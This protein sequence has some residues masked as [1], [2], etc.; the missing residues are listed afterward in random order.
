MRLRQRRGSI[1]RVS[2]WI[3][4]FDVGLVCGDTSAQ[5][6]LNWIRT[7]KEARGRWCAKIIECSAIFIASSGIVLIL[8]SCIEPQ[9]APLTTSLPPKT[10]GALP[11]KARVVTLRRMKML[12]ADSATKSE[13]CCHAL[14]CWLFYTGSEMPLFSCKFHSERHLSDSLSAAVNFR[15][16]ICLL[17]IFE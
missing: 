11:L 4:Y 9:R 6:R 2:N 17:N 3:N 7:A 12:F 10:W 14:S 8:R 1:F 15:Q 16:F 13:A 5:F